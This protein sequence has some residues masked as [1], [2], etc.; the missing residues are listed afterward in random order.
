MGRGTILSDRLTQ[1]TISGGESRVVA[2]ENTRLKIDG[3]TAP[4]AANR[5]FIA[6]RITACLRTEAAR[7]S[8]Y[9]RNWVECLDSGWLHR[10]GAA[11]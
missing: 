7:L 11:R 4:G 2:S 9:C 6:H 8:D 10:K 3:W 5:E 1:P